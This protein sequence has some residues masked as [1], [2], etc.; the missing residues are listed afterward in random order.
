[1]E[2]CPHCGSTDLHMEKRGM[3]TALYCNSCGKWLKW[4]GKDEKRVLEASLNTKS[5]AVVKDDIVSTYKEALKAP[6]ERLNNAYRNG[7][8]TAMCENAEII[9]KLSYLV[10]VLQNKRG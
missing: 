4:V 9:V 7:N 8:M 1:M 2:A 3:Q 10:D 5:N 6:V